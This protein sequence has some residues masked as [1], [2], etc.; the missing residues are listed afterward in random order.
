[1]TSGEKEVILSNSQRE[2][3]QEGL[4]SGEVSPQT[5]SNRKRRLREKVKPAVYDL[6]ILFN[7]LPQPLLEDSDA[8][9]EGYDSNDG[10]IPRKRHNHRTGFIPDRHVDKEGNP[11]DP[12]P[13][14]NPDAVHEV[15]KKLDELSVPNK[16]SPET[17][18]ALVDS[19]AFL[20]R[21]A[22]AG[23]LNITEVLERGFERYHEDR[24][25]RRPNES[26]KVVKVTE[27]L[28]DPTYHQARVKERKGE[29]LTPLEKKVIQQEMTEE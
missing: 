23:E 28:Y 5:V 9:G 24:S 6:Q 25:E 7:H 16:A 18:E 21:A 10:L 12:D 2:N 14:V 22:E 11:R 3:L 19:V 26:E 13:D 17:Q 15:K 29:T 4:D 8:F 1:M 20:C 27:W